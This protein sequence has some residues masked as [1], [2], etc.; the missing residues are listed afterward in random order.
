MTNAQ[1]Q[2]SR[3][4]SDRSA[5]ISHDAVINALR[6]TLIKAPEGI[7][8]E[9]FI[10]DMAFIVMRKLDVDRDG[11]VSLD[12]FHQTVEQQPLMLQ[13]LGPCLPSNKAV[14]AF[15]ATFTP[16]GPHLGVLQGSHHD[17]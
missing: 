3:V 12:D 13:C 10:R 5:F 4:Y 6:Q 15:L 1:L 7:R 2:I 8:V 11:Q 14:G 16:Y 17:L 9:E